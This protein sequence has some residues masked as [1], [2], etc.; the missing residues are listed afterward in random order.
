MKKLNTLLLATLASFLSSFSLNAQDSKSTS[1]D[2]APV[3]KSE[4]KILIDNTVVNKNMFFGM[5][6][7]DH[8]MNQSYIEIDRGTTN[9]KFVYSAWTNFDTK[10][11]AILEIDQV[12]GYNF[13][14]SVG[15]GSVSIQPTLAYYTFP[16]CN[17]SDCEEMLVNMSYSGP[18]NLKIRAGKIFGKDSG[19]GYMVA[20]NVSKT[21]NITDKIST[22]FGLGGVYNSSYVATGS[23]GVSHVDAT[24]SATYQI[25]PEFSITASGTA[26][27]AVNKSFE[28]MVRTE[29]Y[30][31]VSLTYS[32]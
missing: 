9:N 13:T 7:G 2:V 26:Q 11:G 16:N 4:T 10:K 27:N 5:H 3:L 17:F 1:T 29:S 30:G 31:K 6:F 24:L 19:K 18:F 28:G 15:K 32:F 23:K 8:V 12:I 21:E 22:S 20:T 14:R 25:T